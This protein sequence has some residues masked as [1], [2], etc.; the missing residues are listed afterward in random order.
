MP[1][2]LNVELEDG[3]HDLQYIA[4]DLMRA[5]KSFGMQ[6]VNCHKAWHWVKPKYEVLIDEPLQ[7][8]KKITIDPDQKM[9]DINRKNNVLIIN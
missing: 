6:K 5:E 1:I 7:K 2:E 3:S 8:I 4:L 9:A